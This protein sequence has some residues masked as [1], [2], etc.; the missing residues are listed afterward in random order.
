MKPSI[1]VRVLLGY[2]DEEVSDRIRTEA[3][4]LIAWLEHAEAKQDAP[5]TDDLSIYDD[6]RRRLG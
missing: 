6:V 2:A 1:L 5:I 4:E 3:E